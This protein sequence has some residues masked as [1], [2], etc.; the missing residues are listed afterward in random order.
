VTAV[1]T[2]FS[3]LNREP[4]RALVPAMREYG[5]GLLPFY[6]LACGLLTGKYQ[7]GAPPPEGSRLTREAYSSLFMTESNWNVLDKL[8]AFCTARGHTLLELALSWLAAQPVMLSVIAGATKAAQ[9]EANVKAMDWTLTPEELA[10]IDTI[11]GKPKPAG[12]ARRHL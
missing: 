10:E 2:E 3:L 5:V 8:Q 6:P 12:R 7:R 4:E 1:E 9:L 11:T